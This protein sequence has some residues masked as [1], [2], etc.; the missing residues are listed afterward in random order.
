MKLVIALIII[1]I[2]QY[3]NLKIYFIKILIQCI[4]YFTST[5]NTFKIPLKLSYG[6]NLFLQNMQNGHYFNTL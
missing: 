2:R 5:N 1:L 6:T 3:G 4:H